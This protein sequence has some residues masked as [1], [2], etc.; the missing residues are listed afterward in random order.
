[1]G[2]VIS[3]SNVM[4]DLAQEVMPGFMRMCE[5]LQLD[6]SFFLLPWL[7]CLYTKG[8]SSSLSNFVMECIV[9]EK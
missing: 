8:F 5:E 1:M 6:T 7:V 9:I 4:T 3:L 2:A